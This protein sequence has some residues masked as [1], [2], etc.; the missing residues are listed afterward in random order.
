MTKK[1]TTRKS[2][3]K[4]TEALATE[5]FVTARI[6]QLYSVIDSIDQGAATRDKVNKV[7]DRVTK[8]EKK[9]AES[10]GAVDDLFLVVIIFIA[11]LGASILFLV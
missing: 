5:E 7:H 6:A 2:T 10:T 3:R 8:L 9:V 11:L 1:V 4:D